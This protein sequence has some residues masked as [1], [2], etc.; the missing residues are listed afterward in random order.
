MEM[1]EKQQS[2]RIEIEKLVVESQQRQSG[3]GQIFALIIGISGIGAG[4]F[5][6][7]NG[8]DYV[9]GII[10]GSTVVGLVYAFITGRRKQFPV[11]KE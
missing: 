2:H 8:H 9:G 4:T 1:A 10:A 5:L 7:A 3:R 6:A 11:N